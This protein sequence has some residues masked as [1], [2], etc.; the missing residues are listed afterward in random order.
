VCK[1]V[2]ERGIDNVTV[3]NI[4]SCLAV[5]E[6]ERSTIKEITRPQS[7]TPM[8]KKQRLFCITASN[9]GQVCNRPKRQG[10]ISPSDLEKIVG[11]KVL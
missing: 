9:F 6:Q 7:F 2:S 3:E 8:W 5:T 1:L 10:T 4:V 11:L